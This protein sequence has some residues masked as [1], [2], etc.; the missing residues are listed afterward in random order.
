MLQSILAPCRS[1]IT[2]TLFLV[3]FSGAWSQTLYMPR[4]VR[5]AFQNGTRSL[6]GRPGKNYWQNTGR[7]TMTISAMP[8]DRN[9]KGSEEITYINNSPDTLRKPVI[10]LFIN[11]HKPGAPRAFPAQDDYLNAGVHIDKFAVKRTR[12]RMAGECFFCYL[13][14][15]PFAA[16]VAA[17]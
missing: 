8:P 9:I 6:D 3:C 10:K 1:L 13:A 11:I 17:A 7:Y 5:K 2:M 14:S 12:R 16:A 4:D 15:G